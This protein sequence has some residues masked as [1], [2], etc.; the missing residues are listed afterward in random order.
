MKKRS[1]ALVAALACAVLSATAALADDD[2]GRNA[3][4]RAGDRR[5]LRQD[6]RQT[7][8]DLRDAAR[9][10]AL[11]E[12]HRAAG[13]AHDRDALV[14][15]HHEVEA[16]LAVETGEAVRETA[17]AG[18]EVRQ[19]RREVRSDRREIR[20]NQATGAGTRERRDDRHDL[21]GDRRDRRDDRR[22]AAREADRHERYASLRGRWHGLDAGGDVDARLAVLSEL[23]ELAG[24]ELRDDRRESG[25]DR[26]ELREDRRETREDRRQG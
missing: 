6:A 19:D 1:I 11:I 8:D 7:G 4:E 24:A 5:D 17:Q 2:R 10:D 3:V 26:R 20:E 21:R 16:L 15:L 13:A 14:K 18:G 23:R 25:E 9:I 22:D 12:R